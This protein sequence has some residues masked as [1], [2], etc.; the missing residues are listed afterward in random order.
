MPPSIYWL[1]RDFRFRDNQAL[2]AAAKA[3]PVLPVF[4]IDRQLRAQGPASRWRL[5]CALRAFDS[6]FRRRHGSGLM[7]LEDE[8]ETA[9]PALAREIGAEQIH[10]N[11]WPCPAMMETQARLRKALGDGPA[12]LVLH[13]G[14]LLAHPGAVRTGA[15]GVYRVFTPFARALRSLGPDRPVAEAGKV[16]VIKP[17][18]PGLALADLDLAP[19]LYGGRKVLERHALPAG[20]QAALDRLDDFLDHA[21][22][23]GGDRDR[24]DRDATSGLSEHLAVGEISPRTIWSIASQRLAAQDPAQAGIEKFLSEVIWREF[25]WHLLIDFPAMAQKPWR[26]EWRDFPWRG[27]ADDSNQGLRQWQQARTG[28]ALVDA[29]LREMRVT[30][31]M[32]NRV[33][34]VVASWLTKHLLTDWRLGLRHFQDSLTDWDPASNAMN[35]QWV[36]GCGPDASPFFRIF[37]PETQ[38]AKFDPDGAY[39]RRWLLGYQGADGP[40]ARA[41]FDAIPTGWDVPRQWQGG[42]VDLAQGR[43]RALAAY[44]DFKPASD[45]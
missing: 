18:R 21:G 31:R 45:D 29:G 9:L 7:V 12:R 43:N 6:E 13:A 33:R 20:E 19:D 32:H 15:G 1:C 4:V 14:H 36:A 30:G 35:W 5:S 22:P 37:N 28:V 25:A 26:P 42:D 2:A 34:M 10:Q 11:D 3:G 39:R 38:A 17:P 23:Y 41:Y 27:D 16:T 8:P 44:Q 24:P 40:E